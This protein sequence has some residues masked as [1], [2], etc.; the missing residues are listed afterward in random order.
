MTL[1][2]KEVEQKTYIF[3]VCTN[4]VETKLR[5]MYR[6]LTTLLDHPQRGVSGAKAEGEWE[7]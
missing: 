6:M 7:D 1:W 5:T 3:I 2:G 4:L